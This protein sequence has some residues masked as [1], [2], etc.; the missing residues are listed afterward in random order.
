[1]ASHSDA[2]EGGANEEFSDIIKWRSGMFLI[3]LAFVDIAI[4]RLSLLFYTPNRTHDLQS[5]QVRVGQNAYC[6]MEK[7]FCCT[8]MRVV[9]E[10]KH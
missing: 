2:A 4:S 8:C 1:M 5:V 10:K 9:T 7:A 6:C 3:V